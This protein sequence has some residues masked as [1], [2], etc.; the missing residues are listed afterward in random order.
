MSENKTNLLRSKLYN[1]ILIIVCKLPR[2]K[3]E[4][5]APDASSISVELEKLFLEETKSDTINTISLEKLQKKLNYYEG[6]MANNSLT[7][8]DFNDWLSTNGVSIG[9]DK[10]SPEG[11]TCSCNACTLCAY[12]ATK[13][14]TKENFTKGVI[15]DGGARCSKCRKPFKISDDCYDDAARKNIGYCEDCFN[16]LK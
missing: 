14:K 3:T 2:A 4:G 12:N 5:D 16:G 10:G 7:E 9:F 8:K 6:F 1:K 15:T 13:D 11:E